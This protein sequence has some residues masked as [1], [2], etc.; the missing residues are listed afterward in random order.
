MKTNNSICCLLTNYNHQKYIRKIINNIFSQTVPFDEVIIVDDGSSDNSLKEFLKYRK[1]F[2]F[3]L[4]KNHINRGINFSFNK[5]LKIVKSKYIFSIAMDDNYSNRT[6][7]NFK[8]ILKK[9]NSFNPK[10]V[11][12]DAEGE[13]QNGEKIYQNLNIKS[14]LALDKKDFFFFYKKRPFTIFGGNTILNTKEVKKFGG[15]KAK[16]LWHSDWMLYLLIALKNG[17]ILFNKKIVKRNIRSDSYSSNMNSIQKEK[18]IIKSFLK[19]LNQNH[20]SIYLKFKKL[21]ILPNYNFFLF[22]SLLNDK[23][24][25]AYITYGL[26]KKIFFYSLNDL[27]GGLFTTKFKKII[28]S[29]FKI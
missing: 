16:L 21:S 14:F 3:I 15:Y 9:N 28:K 18:V 19:I 17:I 27:I 26:I 13:Y 29:K 5:A 8:K 11:V 4:Q 7:E 20:Y 22:L 25:R 1:K 10:I 23:K 6:V 12:G 24:F 2:K